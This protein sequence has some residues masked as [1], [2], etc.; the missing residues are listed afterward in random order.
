[1]DAIAAWDKRAE[2]ATTDYAYHMCITY[3]SDKVRED[4]AQ[5]RRCT[6]SPPSSISW[7]TR[8]R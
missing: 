2:L 6:A 1:M 5:G 7:P 8:A 4:M 3:W